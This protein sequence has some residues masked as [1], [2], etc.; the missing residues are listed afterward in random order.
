[1][2]LPKQSTLAAAAAQAVKTAACPSVRFCSRRKLQQSALKRSQTTQQRSRRQAVRALE[3][4]ADVEEPSTQKKRGRKKSSRPPLPSVRALVLP[5][6]CQHMS[7][8]PLAVCS[9]RHTSRQSKT[10]LHLGASVC[11][12]ANMV[13]SSFSND[14]SN[15]ACWLCTEQ[16]AWPAANVLV[17]PAHADEG[18]YFVRVPLGALNFQ[19]LCLLSFAPC[20]CTNNNHQHAGTNSHL[21]SLEEDVVRDLEDDLEPEGMSL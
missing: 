16:P 7:S 11:T 2:Q 20:T 12:Q 18:R 9:Q 10:L 15:K 8:R 21:F 3:A 4:Q 17:M 1:M 14:C 19:L 13:Y 6:Q 5:L